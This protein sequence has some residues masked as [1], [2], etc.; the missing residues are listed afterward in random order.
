MRYLK[1]FEKSSFNE[2]KLPQEFISFLHKN[3][4][5]KAET[6]SMIKMDK[7]PNSHALPRIADMI[8]N[9]AYLII[10]KI[11][12]VSAL[13]SYMFIFKNEKD[14]D[15]YT[16]ID[17]SINKYRNVKSYA[18]P[19]SALGMDNFKKFIN[20]GDVYK[21]D[22]PKYEIKQEET[23]L[24]QFM[25][26]YSKFMTKLLKKYTKELYNETLQKIKDK[27]SFENQD[28]EYLE[29]LYKSLK[30]LQNLYNETNTTPISL[31]YL[32]LSKIQG[33]KEEPY[34]WFLENKQ[35]LFLKVL[36]LVF[37]FGLYKQKWTK[38]Q[39]LSEPSSYKTYKVWL[40]DPELKKELDYLERGEKTDIWSMKTENKYIKKYEVFKAV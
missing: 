39:I 14:V 22:I 31:I 6:F 21:L 23:G 26:V 30:K 10:N 12:Y 2:L 35:K 4:P 24:E 5:I 3:V 34:E 38:K 27:T 13:T 8:K 1:L 29:K 9:D 11:P 18:T 15:I 7:L 36:E 33:I 28:T 40:E 17:E 20:T 37:D 19:S 25:K 16:Y 32:K